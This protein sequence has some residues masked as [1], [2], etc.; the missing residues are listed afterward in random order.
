MMVRTWMKNILKSE[1]EIEIYE[2]ESP[3]EI[4]F[5]NNQ[6]KYCY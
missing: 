1:E 2:N 6:D 4:I 3:K 5:H